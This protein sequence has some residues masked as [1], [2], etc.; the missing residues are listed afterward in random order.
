M[1]SSCKSLRKEINRYKNE[2]KTDTEEGVTSASRQR[3]KSL[4]FTPLNNGLDTRPGTEAPPWVLRDPEGGLRTS[5]RGDGH[6]RSQ[7]V[8]GKPGECRPGQSLAS[9]EN[10]QERRL[11]GGTRRQ[12]P[13]ARGKESG[14]GGA[15]PFGAQ[16]AAAHGGTSPTRGGGILGETAD[17]DFWGLGRERLRANPKPLPA[18]SAYER[19]AAGT[20]DQERARRS[21]RASAGRDRSWSYSATFRNMRERFPGYGLLSP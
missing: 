16:D 13:R 17:T 2:Q 5:A 4:L 3:R 12:R 7:Q 19:A 10:L 15:R 14:T 11:P 20:A 21:D 8:S 1:K 6:L 9:S 18:L